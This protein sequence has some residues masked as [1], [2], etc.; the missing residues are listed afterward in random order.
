MLSLL[1]VEVKPPSCRSSDWQARVPL[2]NGLFDRTEVDMKLGN[3]LIEAKLTESDFQSSRRMRWCAAIAT[4]RQVFDHE[5]LPRVA[6][7]AGFYQ[8]IRNVLAA[9]ANRLQLLRSARRAASR[10]DR[11]VV[12]DYAVCSLGRPASAMQGAD[13]A[14]VERSAARIS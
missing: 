6:G 8:L 10:S 7:K 13:V 2:K 9:Y 14:G 3:M 11:T 4:S 5:S 12:C 1:G